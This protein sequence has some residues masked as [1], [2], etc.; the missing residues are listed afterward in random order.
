MAFKMKGSPIKTGMIKGSS[1]HA[2]AVK[3]HQ[4]GKEIW[5]GHYPDKE[6]YEKALA[7]EGDF[8][9]GK[10]DAKS[11]KKNI[12]NVKG[13][14]KF[15]PITGQLIKPDKV[16]VVEIQNVN[17]IVNN[18]Q[19]MTRTTSLSTKD[20]RLADEYIKMYQKYDKTR[21]KV[22]GQVSGKITDKREKKTGKLEKSQK[23]LEQTNSEI[24]NLQDKINKLDKNVDPKIRKN[25]NKE[26]NERKK[27]QK[28][29]TKQVNRRTKKLDKFESDVEAG[30]KPKGKWWTERK[31]KRQE[32]K[33]DQK[34]KYIN[35]SDEERWAHR[36][37]NIENIAEMIRPGRGPM[38]NRYEVLRRKNAEFRQNLEN[39]KLNTYPNFNTTDQNIKIT[40]RSFTDNETAYNNFLIANNA[41][42]DQG[43]YHDWLRW[44]KETQQ[45]G[46]GAGTGTYEDYN[47]WREA[48]ETKTE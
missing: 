15:D 22:S 12:E 18:P 28:F 2:S 4:E 21:G 26:L 46:T 11:T 37:A 24:K 40:N 20:T 3:S 38:T 14:I 33:L 34:R 10:G 5:K 39:N 32:K 16:D 19:I 25:L 6:T 47:K 7:A 9:W 35:M 31:L 44:S 13:E 1:S 29:Y 41:T 23:N 45:Y 43:G 48:Q 30:V 8:T 42:G 27:D 36:Q 17:G